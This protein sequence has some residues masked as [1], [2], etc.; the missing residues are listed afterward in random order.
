MRAVL[1]GANGQLG[2][3]MGF[4]L[5]GRLDLRRLT[6]AEVEIADPV[7]VAATLA[8]HRPHIV[9]NTAAYHQVENCESN[10]DLAFRVNATGPYLLARMCEQLEATLL[11]V[12]TDYVFD[13]TRMTP[14]D[15][16]ECPQPR[17]AYGLSK[18]AGEL[19]VIGACSRYYIVRTSGL[20]GAAGSSGKGGNFVETMLNL[21]AE[22]RPIRVVDD[23]VLAPTYTPDLAAKLSELILLPAPFGIY[24]ITAAGQCSWYDF[25]R[26][27]FDF[28]GFEANLNRQSSAKSGSRAPRPA[29]SVLAN[30]ALRAIGIEQIRHW[31]EGLAEYLK[32]RAVTRLAGFNQSTS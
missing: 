27:I 23:Q 4:V 2:T 29:Y 17:N 32:L 3:D 16:G 15:E 8:E 28:S 12:S 5:E 30:H 9:I 14:R 6:H 10:L 18:R 31:R 26:A 25:A 21:Q 24:H 7:S 20:Y 19:A 13:G 1:I 11:H 22:G